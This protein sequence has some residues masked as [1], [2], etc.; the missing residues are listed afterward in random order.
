MSNPQI[1]T[2]KLLKRLFKTTSLNRF[3]KRY[4]EETDS[5]LSFHVYLNKL[6]TEKETIPANV[7]KKAD[8]ERTY[9]HQLFNGTKM[10]SRDK[11]IQLALGFGM[12]YDETQKLLTIAKR[13][14][15]YPKIRRDAAIIYALE[16]GF[17]I[18][19]VQATL[20]ELSIPLLG[21]ER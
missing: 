18:Q 13:G 1:P 3:I 10:P 17:D 19:A 11:V 15:L 12:K 6:C 8:I 14:A 21:E 4:E 7:I 20:F 2:N 16:N 5:A 9:G